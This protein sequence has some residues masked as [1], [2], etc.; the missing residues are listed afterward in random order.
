MCLGEGAVCVSSLEECLFKSFAYSFTG[1]FVFLLLSCRSS[2]YILDVK[3][4][5]D[6]DLQIFSPIP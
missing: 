1:L 5:R 2:L 4:L 6:N 3:C